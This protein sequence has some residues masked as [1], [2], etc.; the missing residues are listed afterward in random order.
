M[1]RFPAVVV[2]CL[3]LTTGCG[4]STQ[5]EPQPIEESTP[6]PPA[7]TPSF[8]TDPSPADRSTS[9][10]PPTTPP[11]VIGGQVAGTISWI[12]SGVP[13]VHVVGVR[14]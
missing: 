1:T 10:S 2:L 9:P 6:Q 13:P 3:V 12:S 14:E 8:D 5:D 11:G 7:A 4:V